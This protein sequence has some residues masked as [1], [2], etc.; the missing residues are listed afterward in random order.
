MQA[1]G[2]SYAYVNT[3]LSHTH[4]YLSPSIETIISRRTWPKA[5]RVLDFGCGNGSLTNWLSHKGFDA[6]GV[7]ISE[8]GI[9]HAKRSFSSIP[10]S[11]D[12]SKENLAKLGPF[13]LVLCVEVI[14]HCYD[15]FSE[16]EK[17][18]ESLRPGGVLIL[19]T[20]YHGYLKNLALA[21]TG[22]MDRHFSTLWSGRSVQF[23]S[24]KT[25]TEL[26]RSAEF[27]EIRVV[28]VGRIPPLA[29]SMVVSAMKPSEQ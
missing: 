4:A 16:M 26:L 23:F 22:R 11:A 25:I 1:T 21:I 12:A 24:I 17:L 2:R 14:A 6:V 3:D 27:R 28:R 18:W 9:A 7:D 15:P 5:A 8:S 10:F 19:S 20:P 29:K 13:D